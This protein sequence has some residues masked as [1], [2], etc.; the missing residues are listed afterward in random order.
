MA[1]KLIKQW[2][3]D[4][5]MHSPG[6]QLTVYEATDVLFSRSTELSELEASR[7]LAEHYAAPFMLGPHWSYCNC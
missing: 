3:H 6:A 5:I 4:L 1:P 2:H 7:T